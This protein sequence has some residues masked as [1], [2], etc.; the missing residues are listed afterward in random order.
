MGASKRLA[1]I[2]LHVQQSKK[3]NHTKFMAVRF[4]NVLGSSGSVIPIFRKQISEG[5]PI[6]VTDPE[7]TRFFMTVDEAVGLVLQ[8]ATLGL[9]NEIF[10]LDMGK[11][12]KIIDLARQLIELSGLQEGVD[13][14]ISF[15]GLQPGEKLFE[16]VQHLSESLQ[17][18][19]HPR[20]M[21]L[22]S[23]ISNDLD[24]EHLTKDIKSTMDCHEQVIIK[25]IIQK[26][27][28]EYNLSDTSFETS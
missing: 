9:G 18:T 22:I 5:G 25:R 8:S 11:S 7:V 4:G 28:N 19:T 26:H 16:E 23:D 24:F 1:E 2:A 10:V 3:E 21:R 20:V 14:D 12:V 17:S 13:I 6:T 15:T 27:L